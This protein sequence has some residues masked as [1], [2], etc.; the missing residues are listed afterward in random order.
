MQQGCPHATKTARGD[1]CADCAKTEDPKTTRGSLQQRIRPER[2]RHTSEAII[3][4][5]ALLTKQRSGNL[6][7]P[8]LRR[9]TPLSHLAA[10]VE[11]EKVWGL[12]PGEEFEKSIITIGPR[13]LAIMSKFRNSLK[14][15]PLQKTEI[16]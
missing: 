16:W 1:L 14:I 3:P 11:G 4:E 5:Q 9:E 7:P 2:T 12:R 6:F 15:M 13:C 8:S 10:S